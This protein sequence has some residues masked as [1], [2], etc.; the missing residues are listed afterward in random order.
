MLK[1]EMRNEKT[2]HID[3]MTTAQMVEIINEEN[4]N[5]VKAVKEAS[6][7]IVLACDAAAKAVENGGRIFYIGA[8]TSGRLGIA[9]AA[10]C[11]P[12]YGV[13]KESVIGI[14]AGGYK[15]LVQASENA[16]DNKD[17][18]V[19]DFKAYAPDKKDILI[20][21]SAAGG[22]KYVI[23]AIEYAKSIGCLTVGITSNSGTLL[24]KIAD[25]SIVTDTGAEVVT[26]STRMK[27]G[28]AQKL[29][30]N[31]ISTCAMIK[32]GKVYENLM[33]NLKPANNKLTK[34]M[35]GIVCEILGC[36][37][38]EGERRLR[39]N[40]WNIRRAVE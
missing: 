27:A 4:Y 13:P 39:D 16:E 31:M 9:D 3:K 28:T 38:E 25:I 6:A 26:G 5:C 37:A 35:I 7:D 18:G 8:G 17:A 23:G 19:E 11:P 22:A 29:V 1:T 36:T 40:D 14:I 21:I 32:T 24:D 34:R 30:L 33:I 15:S 12:T 10:E 2:K 20:G